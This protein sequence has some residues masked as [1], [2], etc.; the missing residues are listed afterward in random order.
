LEFTAFITSDDGSVGAVR[1]SDKTQACQGGIYNDT[2]VGEESNTNFHGLHYDETTRTV[3]F[4]IKKLEAGCQL[5]VGIKT[6][7]PKEVDDSETSEIEIRRDFY[8]EA[9]AR[10]LEVTKKSNRVHS[11]MEKEEG[12]TVYNVSY[13]YDSDV[14]EGVPTLPEDQ[15]QAPNTKVALAIEPSMPGYKFLG[16]KV[17]KK[18]DG[19]TSTVISTSTNFIMPEEDVEIIGSF[20]K[21][22]S[23]TVQFV[24][25]GLEK[26]EGYTLPDKTYY[27]GEIVLLE[28]PSVRDIID[29][30]EFL[31]WNIEGVELVNGDSFTMPEHDVIVKGNFKLKKYKVDFEYITEI[32]IIMGKEWYYEFREIL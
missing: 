30:Y 8:N 29:G 28:S 31:G 5:T 21:I 15:V 17:K 22:E 20:E 14:P 10:E 9:Y 23:Y 19:E 1:Q 18:S 2:K 13:K 3:S 16:W 6:K 4:K 26:P 27:P 24:F 32:N 11:Y 7:T 25:D 12:T